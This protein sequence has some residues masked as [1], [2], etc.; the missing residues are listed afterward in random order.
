M[1]ATATSPFG[2]GAGRLVWLWGPVA[3]SM[4]VIFGLSDMPSP[5]KSPVPVSDKTEHVVGYGMLGAV[6]ARATA[7]GTLAGLT[8]GA[9]VAAWAIATLYGVSD[10]Y[11]QS[12]VPERTAD[13]WD[14]LADATGAAVCISALWA[15]GIIARSR[16]SSG[17]VTRR[18]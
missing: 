12:F 4:A 13:P 18:R 10:E 17:A 11:H 9:A 2:R 6:T 5:P 14:L 7:G 16:R 8:G 1:R 3:V 15:S